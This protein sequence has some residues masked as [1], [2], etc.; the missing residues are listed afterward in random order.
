[1]AHLAQHTAVGAGD[2]LDGAHRAVG[3]PLDVAAD[4]AVGVHV[5][6][7]HLA[8]L[9]ELPQR[10]VVGHEPALAVGHGHGEDVAGV[11][12]RHPGGL[13]TGDAGVHHAAD[14][15]AQ[16]VEGQ[17]GVVLLG[18]GDFAVGHQAQLN[19]G[20]EAV[21]DAQHQA[22]PGFQQIGDSLG[23]AGVAEGGGDELAAAFGLVAA[24]EAAGQHDDL[25]AADGLFHA[26][27]GLLDVGDGQVLH[28][29]DL[30]LGAGLLKSPG[31]VHLAV[32]AGEGGDEHPGPGHLD[33]R[34]LVL[35]L[36]PQGHVRG[37]GHGMG[38]VGENLLQG[39]H[40]GGAQLL[41]G[42]ALA[43]QLHVLLAG[44]A[45]Q[46]HRGQ[47]GVGGEVRLAGELHHQSALLGGVQGFFGQALGKAEAGLA[48]KAHPQHGGG[49]AA[50]PDHAGGDDVPALYMQQHSPV[51][52]LQGLPV[53]HAV[54]VLGDGQQ[55]EV[56]ARLLGAGEDGLA[57]LG[58]GD[59]EAHQGG[60]HVQ[61]LKGAGHAVLAADGG[62]PHAQ[63]GLQSA[64][65]RGGGLAPASGHVV[66]PLEI[67][68]EGEPGL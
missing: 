40:P 68:L 23:D 57:C 7:G 16:G 9:N 56:G 36:L 63:L 61:L 49:G 58:H 50:L 62:Q 10:L 37:D 18:L 52:R 64:Q 22:V 32:G 21:A 66:E 8:V 14:V 30:A 29:Q 1:M 20:L 17:G 19:Q 31:G 47:G 33:G 42:D 38:V 48:A 34:G 53:G 39:A 26:V 15:A 44:G 3:V 24:G 65:Q 54:F 11:H 55:G 67:F 2:A 35:P 43:T 4:R 45:A 27:D 28:H 51:V 59:G 6:G 25:G 13:H 60:G 46:N 5:L 12:A 41:Q